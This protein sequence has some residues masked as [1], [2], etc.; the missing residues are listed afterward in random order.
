MD[1]FAKKPHQSSKVIQRLMCLR[2]ALWAPNLVQRTPNECYTLLGSKVAQGSS[3]VNQVKLLRNALRTPIL[4]ERIP[5]QCVTHCWGQR[6]YRIHPG[7]I[8]GQI[9]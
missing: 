3:R 5:N 8:K 6:S 2:N 4:V 7:L 9:A 1:D